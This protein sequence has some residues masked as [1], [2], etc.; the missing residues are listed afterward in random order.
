MLIIV[1]LG[2]PGLSYRKTRHNAGFQAIDRIAE[3]NGI[4]LN[5][6]GFSSVYGEGQIAHTPVLLVKPQTFMNNSGDAV[7]QI[8]DYF[9][10]PLHNLVV[11]Y[12]DM[13]LREHIMV[14]GL[15]FP[16]STRRIFSVFELELEKIPA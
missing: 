14:C 7:R 1:G 8:M 4:R 5:K 11:L 10:I 16:V 9:K 15:F 6:K 3:Q 13:V 12:D 2:N